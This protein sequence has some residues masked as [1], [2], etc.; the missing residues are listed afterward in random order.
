VV[1]VVVEEGED[2]AGK[3]GGDV[4]GVGMRSRS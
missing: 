4:G 2:D 3:V 1:V